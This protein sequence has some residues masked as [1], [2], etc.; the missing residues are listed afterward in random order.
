MLEKYLSIREPTIQALKMSSLIQLSFESQESSIT[1]ASNLTDLTPVSISPEDLS[2]TESLTPMKGWV[3]EHF[4]KTI[5]GG[6]CMRVCLAE[7]CNKQ[8]KASSSTNVFKGHW[9]KEHSYTPELKKT[10]FLFHDQLHINNLVRAFI[11]LHWDYNDI[12][13]TAFRK[14]FAAFNPNKQLIGRKTLSTII[15]RKKRE[16]QELV[17]RKLENAESVALTFDIW[18]ARKGSRGFGCATAHYINS[19]GQIV[20]LIINF[21]RMKSPHEAEVLFK[22][23]SR[24]IRTFNLNKRIISI[25]TD[26]ASNN[27]KALETLRNSMEL[28]P[29]QEH[30]LDC[31]HYRCVAHVID[32]GVKAAMVELRKTVS[33]LREVVNGVR[34]SENRRNAFIE[35]QRELIME[36]KQLT[37]G[38]LELADDVD[39]RWSSCFVML[40]RAFLLKDAVD[41]IIV[42]TKGLRKFGPI[43]WN[44]IEEVLSFLKPFGEAT[45]RLCIASDVTI[46][47]VSFIVPK[48][49]A[50]CSKYRTSNNKSIQDATRSL[51]DKL[52]SYACELYHPIVNLAYVLDPRYKTKNLDEDVSD[53]VKA[54]L[55]RMVDTTSVPQT[56]DLPHDSV[57]YDDSDSEAQTDELD[58]YLSSRRE[59]STNDAMAWWRN[60]AEQ[61]PKLFAIARKILPVQAT[62]VASERVFSV[63]GEVD[64]KSRNKLGDQ[65]V[66]NIVLFKS[67]MQYLCIE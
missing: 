40:E 17:C 21:E 59:K 31:V 52:T 15:L 8:Y 26:N 16:L 1:Q 62:S 42:K 56:N 44:T 57:L 55:R 22:W 23:I 64:I 66:E 33:P 45:K 13:K 29:L 11:E 67:W 38:P 34:S 60:N 51:G 14:V 3:N 6:V 10:Y 49:M 4:R 19:F 46:S 53:T 27:I 18:S 47:T 63:A 65:S 36:G 61:Y 28:S 50:H 54:T 5:T 58:A 37:K 32:L 7:G 12:D 39:H 2:G 20:N 9:Q 35:K 48:L 25:T 24:T 30:G 43:D 41:S